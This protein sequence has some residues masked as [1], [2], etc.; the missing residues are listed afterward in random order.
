VVPSS[1]PAGGG[2]LVTITGGPVMGGTLIKVTLCDTAA[3][4]LW[5]STYTVVVRAGYRN[6]PW[7]CT[8]IV[9]VTSTTGSVT[10]TNGYTYNPGALTDS[11]RGG[12][13]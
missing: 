10:L 1:G 4:V 5:S 7:G 11:G 8:G 2:N 3:V 9:N 13:A 12:P 6:D